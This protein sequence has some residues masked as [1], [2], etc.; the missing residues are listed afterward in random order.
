MSPLS[1]S[2]WQ[3][4]MLYSSCFLQQLHLYAV[5]DLRPP[6]S[7]YTA[8]P[9]P[10]ALVLDLRLPLTLGSTIG[11]GNGHWSIPKSL[12]TI[13]NWETLS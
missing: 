11:T 9:M 10:R 3:I 4:L 7:P 12:P 8:L 1:H 5:P 13:M 6:L 2:C